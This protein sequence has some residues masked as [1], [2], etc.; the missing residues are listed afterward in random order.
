MG[1]L[2]K[3]FSA[4]SDQNRL[5]IISAL[6]EYK[7]MCAC[8]VVEL[9]QISG[10]TASK[11]LSLLKQIGLVDS[12]K[13][14]RWVHYHLNTKNHRF[15]QIRS[16]LEEQLDKTERIKQD[17]IELRDIMSQDREDICRKQRGEKCCPKKY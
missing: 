9:L 6:K 16:W 14:G 4:L 11:H 3:L 7:D 13:D 17:R 1:D 5:R 2:I 15:G 12:Y 10:A 8:Q